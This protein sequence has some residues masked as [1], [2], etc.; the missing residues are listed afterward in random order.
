MKA[1]LAQH[2][3]TGT[4]RQVDTDSRAAEV[5]RKTLGTLVNQLFGS[6]L[7][8]Q[9]PVCSPAAEPNLPDDGASFRFRMQIA[10]PADELAEIE[11]ELRDFVWLRNALIHHFLDQHDLQSLEGCR[12]ADKALDD[13]AWRIERHFDKLSTWANDLAEVGRLTAEVL[14]SDLLRTLLVTSR[15]ALA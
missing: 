15:L 7:T 5:G 6:L 10:M 13:A 4:A 9:A 3:V 14:G 11:T 12:L 1:V 8:A 2:E